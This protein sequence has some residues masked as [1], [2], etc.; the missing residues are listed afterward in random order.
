M[1]EEARERH[2][3]KLAYCEEL[4]RRL[5]ARLREGSISEEAYLGTLLVLR[6]GIS[7]ERCYAEWCEEAGELVI[8][9]RRA[10]RL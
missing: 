8:S 3:N 5:D 7:A 6:R 10:Q 4:E 2:A 1:L 9:P